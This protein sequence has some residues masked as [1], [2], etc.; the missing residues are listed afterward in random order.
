MEEGRRVAVALLIEKRSKVWGKMS[1]VDY[2]KYRG[3]IDL[4]YT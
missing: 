4:S 2:F 1:G 3:I